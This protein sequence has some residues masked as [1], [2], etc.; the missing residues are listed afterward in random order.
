VL[1]RSFDNQGK[2]C[3][4]GSQNC[5]HRQEDVTLYRPASCPGVISVSASGPTGAL[6]PYS[7]FGTTVSIM[8]PGGDGTQGKEFDIFGQKRRLPLAV[9][10]VGNANYYYPMQGTSQ[11]APHVA[12]AIALAMSKDSSLRGKPDE[13]ARRLRASAVPVQS[14]ACPPGK[15]CG[16]GQ[17]DV[18]KLINQR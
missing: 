1:F 2:S 13:V 8:A 5:S 6:A 4:P 3:K 15:P 10:S 18:M 9:W 17:L 16:A 11:A 14:G 7:N 12:G